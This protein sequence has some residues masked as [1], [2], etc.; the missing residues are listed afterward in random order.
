[1]KNKHQQIKKETYGL[2]IILG[3]ILLKCLIHILSN[4]AFA[5]SIFRDEFYY[6]ACADHLDIG[7]VDHPPLS[8]WILVVNRFL[9][10][11]SLIAVRFLPV[12]FG[13][14]TLYIVGP[15]VRE[16]KGGKMAFILAG[17]GIAISPVILAMNNFYSMNSIDIFLWTLAAWI[18]IKLIKT[19]K[20]KFWISMGMILGLGLLNKISMGWFAIGLAVAVVLTDLRNSLKTKWPY[21]SVL[22]AFLCFSPYLI[23]NIQ[24]DF[25]HLEFMQNASGLKYA[26]MNPIVLMSNQFLLMSP[27]GFILWLLGMVGIFWNK[28]LKPYRPVV[29]IGWTTMIILII[30]WNS[31]PEYLSPTIPMIIPLGALFVERTFK[32]WVNVCFALL[33]GMTILTIPMALPMLPVE[34]YIKFSQTLGLTHPNTESKELNTLPQHYAD[35]FGWENMAE[36]VSKAYETLPDTEKADAV[37]LTQNYGEASALEYYRKQYPLPRVLCPHNNYWLW[38]LKRAGKSPD[39]FLI[40]GGRFEDHVGNFESLQ[41]MATIQCRYCM[42]YENNLNLFL[43]KQFKGDFESYWNGKKNFM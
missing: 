9:L 30:N 36:Q 3:F 27:F 29:I 35:M 14:L 40:L 19:Q 13:V 31:K 24:N 34:T 11:D 38:G 16:L 28:N 12:L 32:K 23:W 37:V 18:F 15:I 39:T 2:W 43:G 20:P 22:I 8:I 42:P 6:L 26:G 41:T 17:T 21:I 10:G 4:T 7:Y 25:A 33:L 1:M 5:Y